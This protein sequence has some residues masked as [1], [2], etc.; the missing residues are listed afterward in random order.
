MRA[1]DSARLY[2]TLA[3]EQEGEHV[4]VVRLD[5]PEV[6]N[7][8]NTQM[9]RDLIAYF[10]RVVAAPGALRCI[11]VTGAGER[12]FCSGAD[13]K[14]RLGMEEGAWVRQHV[15]YER[16]IHAMLDCP[17]P[18][19][20]AVNGFAYGHGCEIAGC[21]D[22]LYAAETA[23]FA[24][25]ETTLGIMPGGGGTQTLAR[26]VGERRAKELILTGRPFSAAEACEWG[27]VNAVFAPGEL[28]GAVLASAQAVARS[29]PLAVHRAKQAI[30]RGLQMSI[31]DG[32]A[33]ELGAYNWLV[34]TQDRRE[35]VLAFNEKRVPV[36][37]GR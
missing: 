29:A 31:R 5:R 2:E 9:G 23:R 16:L 3:V 10:E 35:G 37:R 8:L 18:I 21:C 32:Y 26:A 14:E 12:A 1:E 27:L 24:L 22:F 19:V 7:A 15:V 28:M 33:F 36:F 11:V 30:H 25:P 13:L 4:A 20:G 6:L 34:S 17:V